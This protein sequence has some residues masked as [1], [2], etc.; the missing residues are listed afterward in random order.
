MMKTIDENVLTDALCDKLCSHAAAESQRMGLDIS[1][2]IADAYGLPR[3]FRRFGDALPLSAILVPGKSWT[4]AITRCE[5]RQLASMAR[6]GG[7]LPGIPSTDPRL[8]LVAGGFPLQYR[9]KVVG[10]IGVGGGTEEQDIAIGQ[11]VMQFF[12]WYTES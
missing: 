6:E 11:S 7:A 8:V 4:A 2:A 12:E 5:T 3:L 10:A 1:F 9:G